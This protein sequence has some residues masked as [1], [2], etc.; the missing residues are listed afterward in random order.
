MSTRLRPSAAAGRAV[1]AGNL[2]RSGFTLVELLVVIT[3]IGILM[4]MTM[5]AVNQVREMA[6]QT[7]CRNNL[8][9]IGKALALYHG[10]HRMY[11]YGSFYREG[12]EDKGSMLTLLLPYLDNQPLYDMIVRTNVN[13]SRYATTVQDDIGRTMVANQ[14]VIDSFICPSD[15]AR[16][17]TSGSAT[18]GVLLA[19][20]NYVG[21]CG[22]RKLLNGSCSQASQYNYL[23]SSSTSTNPTG[24]NLWPK[25]A[26]RATAGVGS[27]PFVRHYVGSDPTAPVCNFRATLDS[28]VR[29]GLSNTIFVGE[30]L[31]QCSSNVDAGWYTGNNGCG[32]VT[33]L[34][35]INQYTCD[36]TSE[37]PCLMYNNRD[38]SLGF[39]SSHP[40]GA[41]FVFGDSSVRFIPET[42]DFVT[43]Q[44]IGAMADGRAIN[45][46]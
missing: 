17:M 11:P 37:D 22:P 32:L 9:Q 38:Y 44:Y 34:V 18:D 31:V 43:Y 25:I 33:T 5:P 8:A 20:S 23:V 21:S 24:A 29:D 45:L 4:G 28:N 46:E 26:A 13:A 15:A 27:G 3:I 39:K 36:T 30:S 12:A 14:V 42:V 10:S 7:T 41:L 2:V 35:P 1:D 16:G 40:G 6:R 19:A